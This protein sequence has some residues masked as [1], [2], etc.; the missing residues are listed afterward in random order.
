MI[1]SRRIVPI[2]QNEYYTLDE[3]LGARIRAG[4]TAMPVLLRYF[5]DELF[6]I[7]AGLYNAQASIT[8]HD[9]R[10]EL[11]LAHSLLLQMDNGKHNRKLLGYTISRLIQ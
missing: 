8:A 10:D 5:D 1:S 4:Y 2:P 3:V 7:Y 9:D 11:M 6:D